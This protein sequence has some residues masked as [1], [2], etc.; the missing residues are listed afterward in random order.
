MKREGGLGLLVKVYEELYLQLG[1]DFSPDELLRAAQTLIDV[2]ADEHITSGQSD[3][4][5]QDGYFSADTDSMIRR[6][7]W[8][9]CERERRIY[10][11]VDRIISDYLEG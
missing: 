9:V 6:S 10:P 5:R 3:G 7:P 11:S 8:L 1:E 2:T 4:I